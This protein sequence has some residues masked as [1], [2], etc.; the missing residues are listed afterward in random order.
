MLNLFIALRWLASR[1]RSGF[2]SLITFIAV[3]GVFVGV[4][5]L[6][7]VMGVMNGLQKDLREKILANTPHI[8]FQRY[9]NQPLDDYR[10]LLR[11]IRDVPGVR[12]ASPF[13]YT[14][15]IVGHGRSMNEG[16]VIRGVDARAERTV[17]STSE[18]MISGGYDLDA[19]PGE[20]YP[21]LIM[22]YLMADRLRA[23]PGDTLTLTTPE[24]A[25]YASSVGGSVPKLARF[26]LAGTFKT[27]LFEYDSKFVYT[28][29]PALQ[30]YLSLPDRAY[31][32][33]VDVEDVYAAR[34]V[35]DAIVERLDSSVF[36]TTW[37]ELNASLFSAL[38]LEKT[39]MFVILTLIVLV[40]AF[41]IIST[42]IMNVT[43][44]TKEIG[45]L[46]S[47]GMRGRSILGVFLMQGLMIGIAGTVL[48]TGA[49][50][51]VTTLLGRYHF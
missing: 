16:A 46:R 1:K 31:G 51:A 25:T 20:R 37:M 41:N 28:S 15:G 49:G 23:F 18:H 45:I 35:A 44:K 14:E 39:A 36:A 42:L 4:A 43:D 47:M 3:G 17:T 40:A 26:V 7:I 8:V 12:G 24:A 9:D 6:I 34:E 10:E 30:Q 33:S 21:R 32:I 5:A 29:L 27:G 22:G 13:I 2:L 11:R 50:L 48:G 38:K 19:H